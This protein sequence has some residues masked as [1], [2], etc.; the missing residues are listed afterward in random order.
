[1]VISEEVRE[2][3]ETSRHDRTRRSQLPL[4]TTLLVNPR[5]R[6]IRVRD[7]LRRFALFAEEETGT[8][9]QFQRQSL[10]ARDRSAIKEY[11]TC[12]LR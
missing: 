7:G 8:K 10:R 11:V 5:Q 6:K 4:E 3:A 12:R 1:M 2:G 9:R